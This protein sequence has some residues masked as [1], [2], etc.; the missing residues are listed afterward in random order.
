MN[1]RLRVRCSPITTKP[2]TMPCRPFALAG[3]LLC[4]ESRTWLNCEV[5]VLGRVFRLLL[6]L[7]HRDLGDLVRWNLAEESDVWAW[8]NEGGVGGG[9]I[10]GAVEGLGCFGDPG[11]WVRAREERG[12]LVR[13]LGRV[14]RRFWRRWCGVHMGWGA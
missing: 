14:W 11:R 5:G 8:R 4:T 1:H 12:A 3:A 6:C 2:A 10:L 7:E 9:A 13:F